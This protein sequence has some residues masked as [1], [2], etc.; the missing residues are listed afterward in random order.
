MD[1]LK[2]VPRTDN[3]KRDMLVAIVALTAL[4]DGWYTFRAKANAFVT[5]YAALSPDPRILVYLADLKFVASII[6]YGEKHFDQKVET[7]WKQFS[8]KIREI[9]DEHLDVTGLQTVFKVRSMADPAF[10]EDFDVK[11]R[12]ADD[13]KMAAVRKLTEMKKETSDRA[14]RNPKQY[15]TF[16]DRVRV[17]IKE[18]QDGLLNAKQAMDEAKEVAIA[19]QKEDA[20]HEGSGL[21]KGAYA[22]WKI[23]ELHRAALAPGV[24]ADDV[25]SA[26]AGGSAASNPLEQAAAEIEGLYASPDTAPTN[27][28]DKPQL[29][30]DLRGQVRRIVMH[31]GLEGWQAEI[32]QEVEHYAVLHYARS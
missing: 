31:L 19:V 24:A 30:K 18:F 2:D 5:A 6:P 15:D 11:A 8:E 29:K 23:L 32:P 12:S 22:V 10:W 26:A 9:L 3:P 17:L 13:L 16:A 4:E 25:A 20:A 21:S 28:Q 14:A 7:D 1:L 27:W